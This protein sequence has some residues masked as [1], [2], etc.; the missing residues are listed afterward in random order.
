MTSIDEAIDRL[1][2]ALRSAGLDP[3]RPPED[4][5][6]IGELEA[7]VAPFEVPDDVR[8]LWQRVDLLTISVES[9]LPPSR[10][11]D[12]LSIYRIDAE[13][14]PL[15]GPRSLLP[16]A[17]H[18]DARRLVELDGDHGAGGA[19]FDVD[20]DNVFRLRYRG[21]AD[22]IDV[23]AGLVE[24]GAFEHRGGFTIVDS[25]L[26]NARAAVQLA[27]APHP[28]YGAHAE[29]PGKLE[30]WPA[31]WLAAAGI[32]LEDGVPL[33]ATHTIAEL[34]AAASA[35]RRSGRIAGE[36]V[37][38]LGSGGETHV[39]VEDTTGRLVVFCPS[40]TSP[41]RPRCGDRFEFA[42]ALGDGSTEARATDVR[43]LD[44]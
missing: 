20:I 32:R 15:H 16:L 36:V 41:W 39:V 31:R 8:R 9:W 43:P 12:C 25:E 14:F 18:S 13:F 22:L 33:G 29:F 26:A 27:A 11:Q 10:P 28:V 34:V 7:E 30:A 44:G 37:E 40:G 5:S 3:L 24:D 2:G 23:L 21:I 38:L 6:A 19:I 1:D 17:G 4:T 35:G 42:V